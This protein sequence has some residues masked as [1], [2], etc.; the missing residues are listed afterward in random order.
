MAFTPDFLPI[1]DRVPDLPHTWVVGGFSGHGMPFGLRFG[2]LLAE[3]VVN[4]VVSPLLKPF[5]FNRPTL[6]P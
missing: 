5:R 1:A 2:Q 6:Q 4:G 3:A